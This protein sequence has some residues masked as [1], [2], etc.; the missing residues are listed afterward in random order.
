MGSQF[1]N[2]FPCFWGCLFMF[3][4]ISFGISIWFVG[5]CASNR[6]PHGKPDNWGSGAAIPSP[7][8]RVI[9]LS[10]EYWGNVD[11][12]TSTRSPSLPHFCCKATARTQR[13][14][15]SSFP[16]A[17]RAS[18]CPYFSFYS[19]ISPSIKHRKRAWSASCLSFLLQKSDFVDQEPNADEV[20]K[21]D[22]GLQVPDLNIT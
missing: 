17:N 1:R 19:R 8:Y 3:H 11:I 9:N 7:H 22:A 10:I 18:R 16:L 6:S 13:Q 2:A 5:F 4:N 20:A 12:R 21:G 15:R 14:G